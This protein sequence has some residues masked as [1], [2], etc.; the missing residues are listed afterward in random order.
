LLSGLLTIGTSV[1]A[2]GS[3]PLSF[4][5][6]IQKEDSTSTITL[7]ALADPSEEPYFCSIDGIQTGIISDIAALL[8]KSSNEKIEMLPVTTHAEYEAHLKAKDYD[9]L[10]NAND[11]LSS[12]LL[13]GY[14]L[15]NSYLNVSY[16]KVILR[17]NTKSATTIACLGE[18]SMAGLYAKSFYYSAQ[19]KA[20]DTM[21][22]ALNAVKSEE[23]YAAIVN[24][25][26]AQ[27][28]QN[29]DIRS[30]YYFSKLSEG[31]LKLKIA[32]KHSDDGAVLNALNASI[33][34]TS[35]DIF[36]LIVSRYSHFVKP[37]P[38]LFDQIY[39]N[40]LPYALGL[41]SLILVFITV[42]VIL[43]Y[44][45]RRKA[46]VRANREFERFITYVCQNNEAVF[47][48][49]LQAQ[50]VTHYL[51][52]GGKVKTAKRPFSL[53]ENFI[54][55]IYPDERATI[56][57]E[58][59]EET[60]H[61]LIDTCGQETFEARLKGEDG[62]YFWAYVIIQGIETSRSQPANFMVFVHSIEDQKEKDAHAKDLLQNAVDQAETANKSKSEFLARMSHEIRTPLNAII[63]LATI[64]RNY[65]NDPDKVEDCL[66][67]I[68]SSSR[69]LLSL[70]N[71]I[72]DMSAIENH[73]MKLSEIPFDLL[74]T[75]TNLRDIYVPQC[76]GKKITF[77]AHFDIPDAM[78]LG[79]ELR[80][81]QI[82]L[83]LLSNAYKF[84]NEG[85]KILF[86]ASRTSVSNK[87][88]YY[89]FSVKDN[90]VGMS[91]EMQ[92]RLF[93]PFEQEN[94]ETA[95]KYGG[96]GLGLSIVKSLVEMMNGTISAVSSQRKGTTFTVDLPFALDEEQTER[97]INEKKDVELPTY[98]FHGAKVLLAEDNAINRE[99]ACEL[100]KMVNL[101]CVCVTNG[102]E[103][104]KAFSAAKEGEYQLILMD[105][106]MPI[107][108]GYEATKAIRSL[109]R[110][111][112]TSIP[113]YA[114]TAN[115]YSEDVTHALSAG[116]NGHIAKPID[117]PTLYRTIAESLN[118]TNEKLNQ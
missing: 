104:V 8:S 77:T 31:S 89:R 87:K 100:L 16:S 90:G 2:N 27:K 1:F 58:M 112:A 26:Y 117:P 24:S 80:V 70:I 22:E 94:A 99:I 62:N 13:S 46:M 72:L 23:C 76:K 43:F 66:T 96:S 55:R 65:D 107:M 71:D 64:A 39:L 45:G 110:G 33:N 63:G 49:D 32:V 52:E 85:G 103:A 59:N 36:D 6:S 25:I 97:V 38:T 82:L 50:V 84:T 86:E 40:P 102:Q 17:N 111:D 53:K 106:Q 114:M 79:D 98:D 116:M 35:E 51:L 7:K 83:N 69:V 113:I 19:I 10:L 75:L 56:E 61:H 37:T 81:S 11:L 115:A 118:A 73:K 12:D 109:K 74:T 41:G 108:N 95:Q 29:E 68:D 93:K 88:V 28:L 3:S 42:V 57:Q 92:K 101:L 47:E 30:V 18:D 14:D 67:K 54:D 60:L 44:A 78:V 91:E 5:S 34:A 48:V 105:I 15:S 4:I 20:Y 21:T 9:L